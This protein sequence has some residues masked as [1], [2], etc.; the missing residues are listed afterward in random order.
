MRSQFARINCENDA[1][2]AGEAEMTPDRCLAGPKALIAVCSLASVATLQFVGLP[3]GAQETTNA[4]PG[5]EGNVERIRF[6]TG[7][8]VNNQPEI[9]PILPE[10]PGPP[11]HW[12]LLQWSQ[13]QVILP[14]SLKTNDPTTRDLRFGVAKYAFSA[15][16]GHSHLWIYEDP[17]SHHP[18]YELY[19]HGGALTAA[20]GANVF[21][22]S[23]A[24]PGGIGLDHEL[25]YEMDAKIS[26]ASVD[27]SLAAQKSG[28]VLAQVFAGFVIHFPEQDGKTIS[29]L[30]LQLP[31]A[32]SIAT[33][34][35]YRSCTSDKGRRTIIFGALPNMNS[36]L[37]FR[38]DKGPPKHL[39]FNINSYICELINRP[40]MCTDPTGHKTSWSLLA[41][42]TGFQDWKLLNIYVGLET[43]AQDL[44]PQSPTKEPQGKVEVALQLAD[45][46]VVP[47]PRHDFNRASCALPAPAAA[48]ITQPAAHN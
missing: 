4:F 17:N 29:T 22:A 20:G 12:S 10:I 6:H 13:Q 21:L 36:Y 48:P 32:R 39:R 43:E 41:S 33:T 2:L 40:V 28:A 37:Q 11:S 3:A 44:R 27:A 46:K 1:T 25:L 31:I 34:D 30:F 45:L 42:A 38:T 35:E 26:N 14:T 5:L 18:V 9:S 23:D 8:V 15:P 16:D 7:Q 47:N 19:E 24:P